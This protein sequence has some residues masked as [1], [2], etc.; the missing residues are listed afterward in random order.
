MNVTN[1]EP[2]SFHV[3]IL[4][5]CARHKRMVSVVQAWL[6]WTGVILEIDC[7]E[8]RQ[9][10]GGEHLIGGDSVSP[11]ADEQHPGTSYQ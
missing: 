8:C 9:Q 1:S 10:E 11:P 2:V 7:E 4:I 3:P 6:K 5:L